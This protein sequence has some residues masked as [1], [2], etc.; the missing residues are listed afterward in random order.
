MNKLGEHDKEIHIDTASENR[1]AAI[2]LAEQA[3]STLSLFTRDLDPRVFDNSDFER[4]LFNLVRTHH[5]T[6]VRI[7]VVDSSMAVNRGHR[8]I[9]LAQK[10]T[11]S[12]Y[13]H[14]PAREHRNE[15]STFMVADSIGLLYRPRTTSNN[16]DAIVNY[17]APLR[18]GELDDYFNE[19]WERS[20][21]DSQVRRLY[22]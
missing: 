8:L 17:K 11:S 2:S 18:A 14:N 19:M 4:C 13:I 10:L 7:L 20:T 22:I 15:I 9:R 1:E 5:S 12:V 21:P 6:S 3:R 16:Y